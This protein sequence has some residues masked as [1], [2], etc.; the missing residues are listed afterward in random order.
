MKRTRWLAALAALALAVCLAPMAAFA[1]G[2]GTPAAT[3]KNVY[4]DTVS[5]DD[6]KD[7]TQGSPVKTLAKALELAGDGDTVL[8]MHMPDRRAVA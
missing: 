3:P 7:G 5:G 6:A 4:L 8:V 1:T 2:D